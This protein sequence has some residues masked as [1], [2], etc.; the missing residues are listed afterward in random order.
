MTDAPDA[1]FLDRDGTII[2]DVHFI[3]SPSQVKLIPGAADAI[4]RINDAGARVVVVTNQS[5][6]ARGLSSV[7]DY[8]AVREHYESL[9]AKAGARIDHSY[10]CPH[11]PDVDGP[12]KCRKP[13]TLLF[14]QA[15]RELSLTPERVA[16]VGDRWRD[17]AAAGKLGGRGILVPSGMTTKDDHRRSKKDRVR[18]VPN[19]GAA[20]DVLFGFGLPAGKRAK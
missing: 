20:V 2:E 19:L 15:M 5:G 3:K 11:H 12:C 6:I 17:V 7:R 9:L 16:Y 10:Y 18:S 13:G 8:E 14:E 4:R 1:V